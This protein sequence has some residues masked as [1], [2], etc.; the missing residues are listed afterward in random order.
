MMPIIWSNALCKVYRRFRDVFP[1]SGPK[2]SVLATLLSRLITSLLLAS[3]VVTGFGNSVSAQSITNG[4]FE[5]DLTGWNPTGSFYT[6]NNPSKAHTGSRYAYFG[7]AADGTTPLLNGSGSTYQSI[8]IPAG[9]SSATLSFWL[10]VASDETTT[11][12][13]DFLYVEALTSFGSL[14]ATLA[15]YSNLNKSGSFASTTPAYQ[16]KF[17]SL[18]LYAGQTI[19][20]RFRGTTDFSKATIFR[21]DDISLTVTGGPADPR[22]T[23]SL[24]I[25]QTGP[26][27]V[28]QTVTAVFSIKNFG[29]TTITFDV[30]T[31]GGRLN[32]T[33]PSNVCPDFTIRNSI[34]LNPGATY[35]YQGTRTFSQAGNYHFFTYYK[36][37]NGSENTNIPKEPGISNILDTVVITNTGTIQI[38]ATYNGNPWPSSGTGTIGFQLNGPQ[39][40]Q[41]SHSSRDVQQHVAGRVSA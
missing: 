4:G 28:G 7:V 41:R 31:A 25:L 6:F 2:G 22:I 35:N 5:T 24:R 32:G 20:V 30:L 19:R 37:P 16:Q 39:G 8:S 13:V 3:I 12:P 9:A 15:T 23:S 27:V 14:L 11:T 38:K 1:I 40:A 26:Y 21:L 10:W 18:S 33:C 36:L 17:I 34:V 29:G